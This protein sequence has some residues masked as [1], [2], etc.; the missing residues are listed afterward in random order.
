MDSQ[1]THLHWKPRIKA[2]GIMS[3]S[4]VRGWHLHVEGLGPSTLPSSWT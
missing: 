1:I 2:P 3:S 4:L